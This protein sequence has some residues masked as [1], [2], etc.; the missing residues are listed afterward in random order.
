MKLEV[1]Q[2]NFFDDYKLISLYSQRKVADFGH[3]WCQDGKQWHE[4]DIFLPMMSLYWWCHLPVRS[5]GVKLAATPGSSATMPQW[6]FVNTRCT[7][8]QWAT[9]TTSVSEPWTAPASA[10]R[11]ARLTKWPPSTPPRARGCK[12]LRK[13]NAKSKPAGYDCLLTGLLFPATVIKI[14]GKYDIVIKDDELEGTV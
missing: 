8:W 3:F 11:P 14:E 7:A 10:G 12:V 5:V 2:S 13:V 1:N 4:N 6:R 9:P